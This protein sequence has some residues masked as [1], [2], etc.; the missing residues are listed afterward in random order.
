[1]R[2][3]IMII[4]ITALC[5][6]AVIFLFQ[7][8][9]SVKAKKNE[10]YAE[11]KK[12]IKEMYCR[13]MFKIYQ[14]VHVKMETVFNVRLGD[15]DQNAFVNELKAVYVSLLDLDAH[16]EI[17]KNILDEKGKIKEEHKKIRKIIFDEIK[18]VVEREDANALD[19]AHVDK[20]FLLMYNELKPLLTKE[21]EEI[22]ANLI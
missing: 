9:V 11:Y 10:E 16:Y 17:Y 1:M 21:A 18:P 19:K 20:M 3:E 2:E 7:L 13:D 5:N 6:D 22:T 8:F 14:F 4:I 12:G 15:I